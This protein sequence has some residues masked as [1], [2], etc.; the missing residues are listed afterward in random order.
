MVTAVTIVSGATTG[1]LLAIG[2]TSP[3][4]NRLDDTYPIQFF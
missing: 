4:P 1:V 2:V 3:D